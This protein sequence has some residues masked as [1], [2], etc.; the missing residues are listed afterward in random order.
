M[1][2]EGELAAHLFRR[3]SGR[4]VASL[5]RILGPRYLDLAEDCVQESF[6]RAL[7]RWPFE[8]VPPNPAGWL[9][10]VARNRAIDRLRRDR[11]L[12]ADVPEAAFDAARDETAEQLELISLCCHPSLPEES[13]IAL[14]LKTACGFSTGEIARALLAQDTA[15][16]QRIV[17]AKR[18]IRDEG[19]QAATADSASVLRVLYLLFNEGYSATGGDE[20]LRTDL[21]EEAIRLTVMVAD[22]RSTASPAA[23][24]LAALMLLQAARFE[25]RIDDAGAL[26]VLDEQDRAK[27]DARLISA[28]LERLRRSARGDILTAYHLQAEIASL[29][30]AAA[31]TDWARVAAL[32]DAL[33]VLEPTPVVKLNRAVAIARVAGARKGITELAELEREPALQNYHLLPAVLGAL[34]REA[35]DPARACGYERRALSLAPTAAERRLLERRIRAGS[36]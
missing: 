2:A 16:A 29:H 18:Q 17:R 8:G 22:H 15:V 9:T 30:I 3:E 28:G 34:W 35:G 13:R 24:A 6:I 19:L 33:L 36:S 21:C 20:L 26:S 12:S 27:W 11:R 23:D 5:V 4:M 7:E 10:L 25:A 32:Y 1:A 31:P 14:T